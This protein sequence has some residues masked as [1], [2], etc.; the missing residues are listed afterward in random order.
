MLETVTLE[1]SIVVNPS[2]KMQR[3]IIARIAHEVQEMFPDFVG[4]MAEEVEDTI[5]VDIDLGIYS[6][7]KNLVTTTCSSIVSQLRHRVA[8]HLAPRTQAHA[9][10]STA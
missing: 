6:A 4:D 8:H 3:Q 9:T 1:N 2:Y 7:N 10:H 5:T